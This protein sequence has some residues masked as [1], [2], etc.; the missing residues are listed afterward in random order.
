MCGN[1]R[2]NWSNFAQIGPAAVM[3]NSVTPF[4]PVIEFADEFF[5]VLESLG[6]FLKKSNNPK[7][8]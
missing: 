3:S 4:A 7:F 8:G 2:K 6:I 1:L 5:D